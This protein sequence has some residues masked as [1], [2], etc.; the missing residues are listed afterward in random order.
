M[1]IPKQFQNENYRFV[2]IERGKKKPIGDAWQEHLFKYND[3]EFIKHLEQGGNYGQVGGFGNIINLDC[4]SPETCELA[5]KHLPETFTVIRK[6]GK[7]HRTFSCPNPPEKAIGFKDGKNDAGEIQ[8]FTKQMVGPGSIHES[9]DIYKITKD[10]PIAE[11]SLEQVKFVFRNYLKKIQET[12]KNK[13][14][15]DDQL[16]IM[17]IVDTTGLKLE[18]NEYRG[19]H[20]I[21]GSSGGINFFV[22]PLKN[23]WHCFRTSCDSGGGPLQWIA[24][25]EG[26]IDCS[27]SQPGALRGDLFKK[28]LKVAQEKYGLKIAGRNEKPIEKK[29]LDFKLPNYFTNL[30]KDKRYIIDQMLYPGTINMLYSKPG[31]FKSLLTLDAAISITNK[32]DFLG[33][34]TKKYPVMYLDHENNEQ[35]IKERLLMLCNGKKIKR[36]N[37]PLLFLVRE[38][39]LDSSSFVENLKKEIIKNKVK[40]LIFDTLHRFAQYEE[41]RADDINRLYTKIFIPI[42]EECDCAILFLHHATKQGEYRGS[43]DLLGMV[44]VGWSLKKWKDDKGFTIENIKSRSREIMKI[45]GQVERNDEMLSTVITRLGDSVEKNINQSK[46]KKLNSAMSKIMKLFTIPGMEQKKTF[47]IDNFEFKYKGEYS[48]ATIRRG[49]DQLV[50]L[51]FLNSDKKGK[52]TRTNKEWV[53][54][55]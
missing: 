17:D 19:P 12:Q 22:N 37:F 50:G 23:T 44:D 4:D 18:G 48:E 15:I 36:K 2:K 9:G 20:P 10:I 24:V 8:G 55:D 28:T 14:E 11:V 45:H 6:E 21:H 26:I 34:K 13:S 7:E 35:I 51:D 32:K 43:G 52:F 5:R 16:Q 46:S 27:E 42:V 39:D 29:T 38:G 49:L 41:N 47:I 1:N 3:I 25:V 31:E 30:K 53:S 54:S 33:F 40:L